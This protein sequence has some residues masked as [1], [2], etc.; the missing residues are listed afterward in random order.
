[1]TDNV[2]RSTGDRDPAHPAHPANPGDTKNCGD[3][4]TWADAQNRHDTY[5]SS[6]GDVARLDV[7]YV[8]R[9]SC[10]ARRS[11]GRHHA[12]SALFGR[13]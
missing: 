4:S 8:N 11:R 12:A 10:A 2:N 7:L 13:E 5:Y 1:M 6:S 3:F 9:A